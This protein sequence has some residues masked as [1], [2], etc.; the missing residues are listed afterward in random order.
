M[1]VSHVGTLLTA[2]VLVL[3]ASALRVK[4]QLLA[5]EYPALY[6]KHAIANGSCSDVVQV[7]RSSLTLYGN[8]KQLGPDVKFW[9]SKTAR[10]NLALFGTMK[11]P[12]LS[13]ET[14]DE[15][16]EALR[17]GNCYPYYIGGSVRDQFLNRTPNDAD[18]EVD[19]S[20]A[21]FVKLCIEK[22]GETNCHYRVGKQVAHI[23]NTTVDPDLDVVDIAT[24]NI[25]FYMPLYKL[26]Y[27][28]NAM[29]YDTNGNDVIIDLTGTGSV[30][31][32]N[33]KIRIPSV[34]N[35]IE[36]WKTWLE[37]THA[38][39]RF[40]KLRTKGLVAFSNTTQEFIVQNAKEQ[41]VTN[42]L[43]FAGFYCNYVYGGKYDANQNWCDID[44][45]KCKSAT[46][47]A[48]LYDKVLLQDL[49]GFWT[50]V[51]AVNYLPNTRD[52]NI[53]NFSLKPRPAIL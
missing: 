39:Y 48:A 33:W 19:C 11:V 53:E 18:V 49:Q 10:E 45:T 38:V 52:C 24:T 13:G 8:L 22:W 43:S 37:N 15:V 7:Q 28:V 29:A 32:C 5:S 44:K 40:W 41:M 20:M 21:V 4:I 31:A 2:C 30:D 35:T 6:A 9:R 17:K 34:S 47:N 12:G 14:V 23:G 46:A 1:A 26:E 36:S 27:T 3:A 50:N 51:T 25:T 42:P 16:F